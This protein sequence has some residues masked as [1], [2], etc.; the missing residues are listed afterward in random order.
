MIWAILAVVV[1]KAGNTKSTAVFTS[2]AKIHA[3]VLHALLVPRSDTVNSSVC[4]KLGANLG[5][6]KRVLESYLVF[7]DNNSK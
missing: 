7:S 2:Q 3:N 1:R 5:S 4:E 6:E